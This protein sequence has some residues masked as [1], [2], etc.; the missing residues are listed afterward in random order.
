MKRPTD[1]LT[2]QRIQRDGRRWVMQ[3]QFWLFGTATY[4]DGANISFEDATR[5]G[6][7]FFN[8]LDRAVLSRK[9]VNEGRRL[10]RLAFIESG[11]LR[12]NT[13]IHFYIKGVELSHYRSICTASKRL[14]PTLISGAADIC[15]Q[16]N[17]SSNV[18]RAGYCWKEVHSDLT[19]V[20]LVDCCHLD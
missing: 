6:R 14:W 7:R 11:R 15:L 10:Q 18:E 12:V 3:Q 16:D 19:D 8:A 4:I 13:H 2:A 5:N 17:I 9:Q 20:L 1:Y